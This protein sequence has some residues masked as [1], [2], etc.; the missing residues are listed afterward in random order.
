V[1]SKE[2]KQSKVFQMQQERTLCQGL[3]GTSPKYTKPSQSSKAGDNT[4]K[5][6][7]K[8]DLFIGSTAEKGGVNKQMTKKS[9]KR[10]LNGSIIQEARMKVWKNF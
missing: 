10:V 1:A 8:F 5:D 4:Q 9:R 6:E 2:F 3:Q 7:D